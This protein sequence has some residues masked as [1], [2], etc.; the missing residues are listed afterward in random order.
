MI[1]VVFYLVA[2][3]VVAL[4]AAW[5][6]D[7]P[8]DVVITWPWLGKVIDLQLGVVVI[9]V[10]VLAIV[11]AGLFWLL[12]AIVASPGNVAFFFRHRRSARG[13]QAITRGLIAIGAGDLKAAR[14]FAGEAKRFAGD[15]PLAL[16]LGAQAAQMAG[17]R[18]AAEVF[19]RRMADQ[20]ETR[21]LGLHG[22]FV[23]AQRRRDMPAARAIA[24][25]AVAAN[26]AAGWAA[27]A[28]LDAR[29]AEHDWAGA[30]AALDS[31]LKSGLI[32][33]AA[34]R[35]SRAVLLTARALSG[36]ER[37]AARADVLEAVKLAPGLVPA[38]ALAGRLLSEAGEARKAGRL[39]ETA[40]RLNPHPDLALAYAHVRSGDSAR[41]RLAR[42][43]ALARQSGDHPEGLLAVARAAIDAREFG[44]ARAALAPLTAAPTRRVALMMAEI[45][46]RD[47]GDIGRA[48]E[49]TARAFT[50]AQDPSW[51]ADGLVS[52]RWLPVSPATGRLDAFQWKVPLA[53]LSPP[54]PVI[55]Q[56]GVEAVAAPKP[57]TMSE[58]APMPAAE[59]S[60]ASPAP[61]G[62]A[63]HQEPAHEEAPAPAAHATPEPEHAPAPR[64][65]VI[66]P[67]VT[68]RRPP[69]DDAQHVETV[70]PLVHSPDDPGPEG[71]IAEEPTPTP[72]PDSESWWRRHLR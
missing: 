30:L 25:E 66:L 70:I 61:Y 50:A 48:R 40:W 16:L 24:E 64:Q 22:L 2:V 58:P 49:W 59:P 71:E 56:A 42:V 65:E 28:V 55:E 31:N 14:R 29:C 26:P 27:Q 60:S 41:D 4:G 11:L 19:F 54:G 43:Q 34:Y 35:R 44:A 17:N 20:S 72:P 69:P 39:I 9:A 12:R 52:D 38:A 13:H 47:S 68:P 57:A 15:E 51:T 33:K 53:D 5:L 6:A 46:E 63:A 10:L 7:R 1:R 18:P 21:M 3:A 36:A 62:E 23:E 32:D 8:G 67:A 37:D 45:E